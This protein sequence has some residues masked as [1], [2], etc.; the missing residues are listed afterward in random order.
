MTRGSP[1]SCPHGRSLHANVHRERERER[2]TS[3]SEDPV[4][5]SAGA[6]A[7]RENREGRENGCVGRVGGLTVWG[8]EKMGGKK[9][10]AQENG[11]VEKMGGRGVGAEMLGYRE[12]GGRALM[13]LQSSW[14]LGRT[15]T[16]RRV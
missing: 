13:C 9:G 16:R 8:R 15:R 12:N 3:G 7:E 4:V 10:G 2:G 1:T 14:P 5:G 11:G 6:Q